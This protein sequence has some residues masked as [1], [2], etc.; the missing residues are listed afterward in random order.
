MGTGLTREDGLRLLGIPVL[1]AAFLMLTFT[2]Q[3]LFQASNRSGYSRTEAEILSG[4]GRSRSVR[5]RIASTGE[6]LI[7]RRSFFDSTA[8]HEQLAIW[9]N[10]SARLVFGITLFDLRVV[11]A[12]RYPELPNLAE[13]ILAAL[14]NVALAVG[15]S[16]LFFRPPAGPRGTPPKPSSHRTSPVTGS[17]SRSRGQR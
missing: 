1:L 4:P 16:Y 7:V 3:L 12:Q 8:P 15:G 9:H 2:P 10:P 6:E 5:I 14:I 11:S 13:A 17:R